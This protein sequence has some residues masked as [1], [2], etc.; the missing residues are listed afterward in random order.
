MHQTSALASD[1]ETA[2]VEKILRLAIGIGEQSAHSL[3]SIPDYLKRLFLRTEEYENGD[4]DQW[5]NWEHAYAEN[6]K[7][8]RLWIP[9]CDIWMHEQRKR[10]SREGT[11]LVSLWPKGYKFAVCLTHDVD[12]IGETFTLGQRKRE[13]LRSL[14]ARDL[15]PRSKMMGS[16]KGLAKMFLRPSTRAPSTART[17]ETC[18]QIEK[19]FGVSA[20]YFFTVLPRSHTSKY[21][22]LYDVQDKCH[23]LGQDCRVKDVMALLCQDGHDVGLHGSYFSAVKSGLLAEQKATLERAIQ[24]P[25]NT[26]RQHWLHLHLPLTLQLQEQAGFLADTTLGYNRNI[27]FR[28]GT[29]LPFFAY[30]GQLKRQMNLV[31]VPLV[32]QDGALVGENALEYTPHKAL[33]IVKD[34]VEGIKDVEGCVTFLFHP[35]IFMKPGMASLYRSII[36]LCLREGAWVTDL[37]SVQKWWR[38]RAEKLS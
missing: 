30:D 7:K 34:M 21:D 24:A 13:L 29:S 33:D 8:G 16:V 11:T 26:T 18:Y 3:P 6:Y 22:C 37:N 31:E 35:D 4:R 19:E 32:I 27:G 14:K 15:F 2:Y 20:S 5:D 23:F 17:L 38:E 12:Y 36:D 10:L 9:E 28:A 1:A 25:V